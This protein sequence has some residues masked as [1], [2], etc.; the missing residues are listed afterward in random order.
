MC[1]NGLS[2]FDEFYQNQ[3]MGLTEIDENWKDLTRAAIVGSALAVPTMFDKGR[4]DDTQP[5]QTT[6][7][8]QQAKTYGGFTEEKAYNIV[9]KTLYDEAR[10]EGIPGL[11]AVASVIYNRAGGNSANFPKVCL[12]KY[13]FSVWNGLSDLE[14]T[15]EGYYIVTPATSTQATKDMWGLCQTLT[16]QMFEGK[17]QSTIDNRNV[18]YNPVKSSPSWGDTMKNPKTIG[19]HKFG[20]LPEYDGFKKKTKGTQ[21]ASNK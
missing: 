4:A 18:F 9:A 2:Q 1:F 20:Y 6:E 17:F 13:Q 19:N 7:V 14:R 11:K 15:P 16:K 12:R 8:A 21:I 10:G 5:Q 3:M